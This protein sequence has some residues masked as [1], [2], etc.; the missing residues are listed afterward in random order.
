MASV[1]VDRGARRARPRW[2]P[3]A[4]RRVWCRGQHSWF[5]ARGHAVTAM[6]R[7]LETARAAG[8]R[9]PS[10]GDRGRPRDR[11]VPFIGRTFAGVVVTRYLHRPLLPHLVDAVASGGAL[12]YETFARDQERF[13]RP[14]NPAFLLE[15]G[16]LL[17]AVE[18][19]LRVVAYE[20]VIVDLA[21]KGCAG[22]PRRSS[23]SPPSA[24]RR[25]ADSPLE[26]RRNAD[27]APRQAPATPSIQ[28]R[29]SAHLA[30]RWPAPGASRRRGASEWSSW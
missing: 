16:E 12:L 1:S 21:A 29:S 11:F 9:S 13:G 28:V 23:A 30:N 24:R 10:R 25:R 4:R 2:G 7:D 27:A 5:V 20:D 8:R 19:L 14:T 18:G 22:G 15:P 26:L 6:D 17:E 3:G